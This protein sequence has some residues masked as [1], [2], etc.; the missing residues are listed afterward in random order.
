MQLYAGNSNH[1]AVN[2]SQLL[3]LKS[4]MVRIYALK[5][6]FSE[7]LGFLAEK[8]GRKSVFALAGGK[9]RSIINS[10]PTGSVDVGSIFSSVESIFFVGVRVLQPAKHRGYR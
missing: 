7:N 10:P 1:Y 2:Q 8:L 5:P 3:N 9:S 4:K 6:G